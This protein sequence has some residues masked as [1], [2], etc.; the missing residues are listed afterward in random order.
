[1][2]DDYT[3]KPLHIMLS[4]VSPYVKSY[5][6]QTKLMYSW[7]KDDELLE[8]YNTLWDKVSADKKKSLIASLL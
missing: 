7:I 2:Y 6:E 3:V 5:D 8:K 1:M 4:K